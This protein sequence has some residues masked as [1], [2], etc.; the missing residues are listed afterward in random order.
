MLKG[1]LFLL[2]LSGVAAGSPFI[3]TGCAVGL[4]LAFAWDADHENKM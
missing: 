3:T 1:V 2:F 4:L